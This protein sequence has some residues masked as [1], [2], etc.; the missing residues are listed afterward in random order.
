MLFLPKQVFFS[1][2]LVE[3]EQLLQVL[4]STFVHTQFYLVEPLVGQIQ[5]VAEHVLGTY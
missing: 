1:E 4:A 3:E 5:I 2:Q